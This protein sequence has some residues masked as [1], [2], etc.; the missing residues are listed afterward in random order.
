[1]LSWF[2]H[3]AL[4]RFVIWLRICESDHKLKIKA[5]EVRF[6][7]KVNLMESCTSLPFLQNSQMLLCL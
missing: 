7:E 6:E 2:C 5:L 4:H 1:M 3:H